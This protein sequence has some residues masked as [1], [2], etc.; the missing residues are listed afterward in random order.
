[1]ISLALASACSG[2]DKPPPFKIDCT[3][4]HVDAVKL[5]LRGFSNTKVAP[6][7]ITLWP[8]SRPEMN[9][10]GMHSTADGFVVMGSGFG[11]VTRQANRH[12]LGAKLRKLASNCGA[13]CIAYE[14]S[15]SEFRIRLSA[16]A[17]RHLSKECETAA[18]MR[19]TFTIVIAHICSTPTNNAVSNYEFIFA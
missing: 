9:F 10:D 8:Y 17:R 13:N 4:Q 1:M 14:I 16:T 7:K 6:E 18:M 2:E 15:G 3:C 19:G 12:E 5:N 11:H